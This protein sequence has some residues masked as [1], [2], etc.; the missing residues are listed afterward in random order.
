MRSGLICVSGKRKHFPSGL[1]RNSRTSLG[2]AELNPK[3]SEL[4]QV[5]DPRQHCIEP[6]A[7]RFNDAKVTFL[8]P[9]G[10]LQYKT[11][12]K[13][14]DLP[15]NFSKSTRSTASS[16]MIPLDWGSRAVRNASAIHASFLVWGYLSKTE[17]RYKTTNGSQR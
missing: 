2:D 16:N 1:L 6:S 9:Q 12:D 13:A 10:R 4:P 3:R 11:S 5:H 14:Q 15:P 17:L 8:E 7:V